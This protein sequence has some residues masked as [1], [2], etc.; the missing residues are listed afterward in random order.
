MIVFEFISTNLKLYSVYTVK[1]IIMSQEQYKV[2]FNIYLPLL[3]DNRLSY[4]VSLAS[5]NNT[6]KLYICKTTRKD[7]TDNYA[8]Y[9]CETSLDICIEKFI[10]RAEVI[11]EYG[12]DYGGD[13]Y[14]CALWQETLEFIVKHVC[15]EIIYEKSLIV[16]EL[17]FQHTNRQGQ[18]TRQAIPKRITSGS[19]KP[20]RS[21]IKSKPTLLK[22][23]KAIEKPPFRSRIGLEDMEKPYKSSKDVTRAL[24][25]IK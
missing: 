11:K 14:I 21:S 2:F 17:E 4:V 5:T 6:T 8:I 23:K 18:I 15:R 7:Q 1:V 10:V 16:T 12:D 20:E 13:S 25:D 9:S 3:Q 24:M 19:P 22:I